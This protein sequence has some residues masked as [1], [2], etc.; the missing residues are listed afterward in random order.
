MSKKVLIYVE[1]GICQEVY[2][3]GIEWS[4]VDFDSMESGCCPWCQ[5]ELEWKPPLKQRLENLGQRI[6][7]K[8]VRMYGS[9]DFCPKCKVNPNE[10]GAEW[11]YE[12]W[13]AGNIG[14]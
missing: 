11:F 3:E 10:V 2:G 13:V 5:T 6:M 1:G 8:H 9:H 7:H 4:V 12:Q 14:A